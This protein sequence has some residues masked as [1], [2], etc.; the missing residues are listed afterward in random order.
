MEAEEGG[1]FAEGF[2]AA[3]A[4][5]FFLL[6]EDGGIIGTAM[7]DSVMEDAGEVAAA[8]L[9]L[10]EDEGWFFDTE[11]LVLAERS[12]LRIHEV[13]VDWVD[14]PDSRVDI[15]A[16]AAADI[17]GIVTHVLGTELCTR[18]RIAA[19]LGLHPRTM[20]RRLAAEGTSFQRIKDEV[21]RDRRAA[22]RR[23]RAAAVRRCRQT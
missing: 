13:P 23:D 4:V 11:L 17:R 7:F 2:L 15:V 9:P 8:L 20:V 21:R 6:D 10:I 22:D 3:L 12:G 1:L 18:E 14:D 5:E 16:T 19:E